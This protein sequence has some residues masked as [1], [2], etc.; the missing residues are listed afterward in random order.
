[1]KLVKTLVVLFVLSSA[2]LS[3]QQPKTDLVKLDKEVSQELIVFIRDARL[4]GVPDDHIRKVAAKEGWKPELIERAL[5]LPRSAA[6]APEASVKA[7]RGVPDSYQIGAGDV[8]QIS[9][10]K[11]PD[12][13]VGSVVVRPDGKIAMPLLKEVV[14]LGLTPAEVEKQMTERLSKVI[15]AADVTVIVT[16]VNSK[17]IYV[18]GAVKKEGPIPI[19]YNMT[20]LQALTEAGGLTD[21]A[22]RKKIYVL[23]A[24]QGRQYR[25]PFNYEEV[26]RGERIEQNIWIRPDDT[27]VVPQ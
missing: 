4:M 12:A 17:K 20:V 25:L 27:I 19:K 23:R 6:A 10:W 16:E 26:I 18:I 13:S 7:D 15:L 22:K 1:M 11:E 5:A 2:G 21:Y 8:L 9:V 3:A 24:E 14:V